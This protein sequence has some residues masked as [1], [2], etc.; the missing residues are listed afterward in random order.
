MV[1]LV[2]DWPTIGPVVCE[3]LDSV[4]WMVPVIC[5]QKL[6]RD[7]SA[8]AAEMRTCASA[9]A[10]VWLAAS[11]RA[12]NASSSASPYIFHHMPRGTASRGSAGFQSAAVVPL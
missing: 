1:R 10:T 8:S 7:W 11:T 4:F 6:A 2:A 5:G 12:I 3:G 9:A